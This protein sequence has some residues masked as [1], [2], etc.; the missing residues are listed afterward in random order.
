MDKTQTGIVQLYN[1]YKPI[2][3]GKC[4]FDA[5]M[6]MRMI[7]RQSLAGKLSIEVQR[8]SI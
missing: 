8:A 2:S 1:M 4:R 6:Q 5:Y 3:T 7:M